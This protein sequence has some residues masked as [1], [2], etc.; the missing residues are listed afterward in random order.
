MCEASAARREASSSG[1]HFPGEGARLTG[2]EILVWDCEPVRE[3]LVVDIVVVVQGGSR[4][5][6]VLEGDGAQGMLRGKTLFTAAA[7]NCRRCLLA[8]MRDNSKE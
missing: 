6:V 3:P 2:R 8:I 1:V 5:W 4:L 7:E